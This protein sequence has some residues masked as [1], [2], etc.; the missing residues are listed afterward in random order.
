MNIFTLKKYTYLAVLKSQSETYIW[1]ISRSLPSKR[2]L[3][4][5]TGCSCVTTRPSVDLP[6]PDSPTRPS[7]S[8]WRTSRLTPSTARTVCLPLGNVLYTSRS[9]TSAAVS[10]VHAADGAAVSDGCC[11]R[12]LFF[13]EHQGSFAEVGVRVAD[14]LHLHPA[15]RLVR[16]PDGEEIRFL[17]ETAVDGET[18]AWVELATRRKVGEVGRQSRDG[19]QLAAKLLVDAG[20]GAQQRPGVGMLRSAEDGLGRALLHHPAGVHHHHPGA[21][22]G[23]HRHVVGDQHDRGAELAVEVLELLQDLRLDRDVERG[24]GLV[25]DEQAGLIGQAHG[26]HDALAHAAREL[27]REL[28]GAPLR[29]RNAHAPQ[30]LRHA[31]LGLLLGESIVRVHR[32]LDLEAHLEHRVE[33]RHGV[34]EDHGDVAAPKLAELVVV[35][36]E[37]VAAVEGDAPLDDL[38]RFG[39]EA[40]DGQGGYRLARAGLTD[41]ADGL[42]AI[43]PEIDAVNRADSAAAN[44]ELGLEA[45]DLQ[46]SRHYFLCL[47]SRASRRPSPMKLMAISVISRARAGTMMVW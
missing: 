18:A 4:A 9:E 24:G 13:P 29:V 33:R 5:L 36:G 20:D 39:N 42:A 10:A 40:E 12:L 2:M 6:Q 26:D 47:G 35:H 23:D 25:G 27:V 14:V 21:D 28:L 46:E 34:L 15:A 1:H 43:D 30:Q 11:I 41:D 44:E 17:S 38:A 8:P 19:E 3:P 31:A 16:G 37:H 32:L 45:L 22:A 7:V